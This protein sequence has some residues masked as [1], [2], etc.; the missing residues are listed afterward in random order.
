MT[1]E[2]PLNGHKLKPDSGHPDGRS[3]A[4]WFRIRGDKV[5]PDSGHPNG[6]S[7]ANWFRIR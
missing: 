3:N 4:N 2:Q 1:I 5:K 7:N 6:R